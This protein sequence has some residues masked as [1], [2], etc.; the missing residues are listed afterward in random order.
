M[1]HLVK[2]NDPCIKVSQ[3]KYRPSLRA[4]IADNRI[5]LFA[6]MRDEI[7]M[8]QKSKEKRFY[9]IVSEKLIADTFMQ[10]DSFVLLT[11]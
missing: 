9:N 5:S 10:I 1:L 8:I 4:T 2:D 7:Y 6:I 3:F 11:I